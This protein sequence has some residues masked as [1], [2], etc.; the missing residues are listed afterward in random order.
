MLGC[1]LR[2][3]LDA[4]LGRVLGLRAECGV[5]SLILIQNMCVKSAVRQVSV[6]PDG[7]RRLAYRLGHSR[8]FSD[9]FS[10][11]VDFHLPRVVWGLV[12]R[13]IPRGS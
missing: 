7:A 6:S 5:G 12:A 4:V 13:V 11:F 8:I 9:N 1:E 3:V 10:L 2:G